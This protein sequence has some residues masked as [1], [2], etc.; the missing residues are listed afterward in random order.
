[1]RDHAQPRT[2]RRGA[3]RLAAEDVVPKQKRKPKLLWLKHIPWP[4]LC[5]VMMLSGFIYGSASLAKL[6]VEYLDQ[7]IQQVVIS[8]DSSRLDVDKLKK[9]MLA[10]GQQGFISA[11]MTVLRNAAEEFGWVDTVKIQRFWPYGVELV[12]QEHVPVARWGNNAL[13]SSEGEVFEVLDTE[14]FQV[15][16][17][18]QSVEGRELEMM[19]TYRDLSRLLSPVGLTIESLTRSSR[20]AWQ[21]VCRNQLVLNLGRDQVSQKVSKF[22]TVYRLAL[23]D[24]IEKIERVDLRYTNGLAVAWKAQEQQI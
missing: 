3:S 5:L 20:G 13:L 2:P 17:N 19:A 21:L 11:D 7:P 23:H 14:P 6:L 24:K 10:L 15:L 12:V 8:G 1:M 16:P 9:T 4:L 22:V 18:L